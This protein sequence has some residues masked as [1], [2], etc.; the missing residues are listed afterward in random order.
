M[1]NRTFTVA[2]RYSLLMITVLLLAGAFS[3]YY[4]IYLASREET[5]NARNFRVLD[6]LHVNME[7]K[8]EGFHQMV[9]G[10]GQYLLP[11]LKRKS[12]AER[13]S[14]FADTLAA[15][16]DSHAPW[17]DTN[18]VIRFVSY[19]SVLLKPGVDSVVVSRDSINDSLLVFDCTLRYRDDSAII[20]RFS[21]GLN[22]FITPLLRPDVFSQNLLVHNGKLVFSTLH[23][24]FD[25]VQR[26]SLV[27]L[28]HGLRVSGVE[29][30]T[31]NG[32]DYKLFASPIAFTGGGQ[33]LLI[34][35][36]PAERYHAEKNYIS[37]YFVIG[38]LMFMFFVV[39]G[40]PF[41][42]SLIMSA[43]ERLNSTDV[44]FSLVSLATGTALLSLLLF[45]IYNFYYRDR[46]EQ[47]ERLRLLSVLINNSF[48]AEL[49]RSCQTIADYDHYIRYEGG[50]QHKGDFDLGP[51]QAKN[52][53][54]YLKSLFYVNKNGDN[55]F[56][57]HNPDKT[58]NLSS[59]QYFN[60]IVSGRSLS[61]PSVAPQFS[62]EP[63]YSWRE[64]Q[65][66]VAI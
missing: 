19:Q 46:K 45:N 13:T 7:K 56:D 21:A 25:L 51:A 38:I 64:G 29:S 40:I 43:N 8:R 66:R 3:I 53:I 57:W 48:K 61:D 42:K 32:E 1:L 36:Q 59:R 14:Y 62:L 39:L 24:G 30:V 35:L 2:R 33:W 31:L 26:D 18:A 44:L 63:I 54:T 5:I 65:F 20:V 4:F 37:G 52:R 50:D 15:D 11:K 22:A 17:K 34:G 23:S 10:A 9:R 6:R 27:R 41:I 58:L 12:P 60:D 47:S 16:R 55:V 28:S 49:K